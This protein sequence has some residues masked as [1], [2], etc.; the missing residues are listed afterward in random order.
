MLYYR[1]LRSFWGASVLWKITFLGSPAATYIFAQKL[2]RLMSI[3][4]LSTGKNYSWIGPQV[5]AHKIQSPNKPEGLHTTNPRPRTKSSWQGDQNESGRMGSSSSNPPVRR[6]QVLLRCLG[7]FGNRF[8]SFLRKSSWCVCAWKFSVG[9]ELNR[10]Y[11]DQK[12][13]TSF[14]KRENWPNE[15]I[16]RF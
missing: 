5:G 9:F 8:F 13:A 11:C 6:P 10:R 12:P 7:L 1:G 3:E 14:S 4:I 16:L 2:C 15:P